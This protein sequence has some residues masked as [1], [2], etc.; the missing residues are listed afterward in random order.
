MKTF[1][2]TPPSFNQLVYALVRAIPPGKVLSYGRVSDLL[3]VPQGARAVGWA[4]H[5]LG[6]AEPSVPWHRVVNA[7]GRVS[8]K[9]SPEAAM[10]QRIRLEGEGVVFDE[11][12]ALD[13]SRHLW[14]PSLPEVEAIV[15]SALAGG[16]A[17][18]QT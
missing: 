18:D 10:E 16:R 13:M 8:I 5:N 15:R 1:P 14:T 7:R 4:L 3:G 17:P 9:G 11:N 6:G 2:N 12:D